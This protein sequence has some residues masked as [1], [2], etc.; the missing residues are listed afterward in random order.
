M[1]QHVLSQRS[2]LNLKGVKPELVAVVCLALKLSKVD[3]TV[4]CGMRSLPEQRELVADG[5]SKTLK[6]YHL[7]QKDTFAHAVDLMPCGFDEFDDITDEAWKD[8]ADAMSAASVMLHTPVYNGYQMWGWD[9][10]HWQME[11]S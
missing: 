10:S 1:K 8:V 5:K 7:Y 3:F 2:R 9:R 4:T 6:S 11:V